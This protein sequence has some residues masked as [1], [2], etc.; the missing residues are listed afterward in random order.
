MAKNTKSQAVQT[1]TSD[2]YTEEETL[3]PTP[4]VQVT[5]AI[6]GADPEWVGT[7]STASSESES[8]ESESAKQPRRKPAQTTDNP[9]SQTEGE[10]DSDATSTDGDTRKTG[11][12]Q[13]GKAGK[14]ANVRSTGSD[15]DDDD[16]FD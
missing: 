11:Q 7:N 8:N 3:D 4:P 13:S 10:T 1:G 15:V 14:K 5:R 2:S 6:L 9:S 12:R 16:F